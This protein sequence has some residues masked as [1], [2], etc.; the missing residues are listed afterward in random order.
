MPQNNP[1]ELRGGSFSLSFRSKSIK[2]INELPCCVFMGRCGFSYFWNNRNGILYICQVA[3]FISIVCTIF[4]C[5]SIGVSQNLTKTGA[6]T[7]GT[8]DIQGSIPTTTWIGLSGA[9]W[10]SQTGDTWTDNYILWEDNQCYA[11][12]DSDPYCDNCNSAGNSA[13]G[14]VLLAAVTRIP[15]VLLLQAR[16]LEKADEPLFKTLGIFSETLAFCCFAGATFV[17]R[18]YCHKQLPFQEDMDYKFGGGFILVGLGLAITCCIAITHAAMPCEEPGTRRRRR[19]E[20]IQQQQQERTRQ[21][22]TAR[23]QHTSLATTPPT[24][25][26]YAKHS[27][28]PAAASDTPSSSRGRS[29]ERSSDGHRH[30]SQTPDTPASASGSRRS[31]EGGDGRSRRSRE[32]RRHSESPRGGT[33]SGG[34]GSRERERRGR[35]SSDTGPRVEPPIGAAERERDIEEGDLRH[36][37][38]QQHR[39]DRGRSRHHEEFS[40]SEYDEDLDEIGITLGGE[41][42][43]HDYYY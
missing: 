37:R 40:D 9:V 18:E 34:G 30:Y 10:R 7:T 33:G 3:T 36:Y 41:S 2:S 21:S 5:L 8:G 29:R 20:S 12:L 13:V 15:S 26:S 19:L 14:L 4:G 39:R 28:S 6:W 25:A 1:K 31:S 32:R 38:H 11:D 23:H 27:R 17:W 43:P 22:V 35:R 24:R 16:M 42:R